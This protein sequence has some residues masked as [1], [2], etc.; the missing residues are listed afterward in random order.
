MALSDE[1]T[2][3]ALSILTVVICLKFFMIIIA[4]GGKRK[5]APEDG[6][7]P[8]VDNKAAYQSMEPQQDEN[9]ESPKNDTPLVKIGF[10]DEDRWRRIVQNDMENIPI[11][12]IL[13]WIAVIVD[14]N[15]EVN[16]TLAAVFLFGR[17][18]HSLCYIYQ[19]MPWRSIGW[20]L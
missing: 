15:N 2:I 7:Q 12:L 9:E 4:S 1:D 16:V 5:R 14:G 11:T 17:I 8:K 20:M 3:K 18:M 10:S 13:M 19:L 6:F